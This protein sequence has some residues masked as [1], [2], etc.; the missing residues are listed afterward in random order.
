MKQLIYQ[1]NE[2][3]DKQWKIIENVVNL[4]Y[5]IAEYHIIINLKEQTGALKEVSYQDHWCFRICCPWR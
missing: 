2:R 5:E 3:I 4:S 1:A